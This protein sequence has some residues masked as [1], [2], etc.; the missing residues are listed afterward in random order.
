MAACFFMIRNT[1]T[2]YDREFS[3]NMKQ[4][5]GLGIVLGDR[6]HC[7]KKNRRRMSVKADTGVELDKNARFPDLDRVDVEV[8][9]RDA[10]AHTFHAFSSIKFFE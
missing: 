7:G 6:G 9:M 5:I 8:T 2:A 4:S 3:L 10:V 1:E